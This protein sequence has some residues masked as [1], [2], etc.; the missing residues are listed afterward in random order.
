MESAKT[1][2]IWSRAGGVVSA[3]PVALETWRDMDANWG[4]SGNIGEFVKF[5][6]AMLS[7]SGVL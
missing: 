2:V 3:L 7:I 1:L 5:G 6:V 4:A